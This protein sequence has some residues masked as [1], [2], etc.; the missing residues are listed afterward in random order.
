MVPDRVCII[1]AGAA[2]LCAARHSKRVGLSPVVFEASSVLGGTWVYT[3][4]VGNSVHSSMYKNL[5]TNLPKEVMG[6]PDYPFP[7]AKT[8]GRSF[9]HHS[10]VLEYLEDYATHFDL[11]GSIRF[12]TKVHL[13]K[14]KPYEN[15]WEVSI[16][17]LDESTGSRHH[18][19]KL[20]FDAIMVC[21]GHYYVPNFPTIPGLH[22]FQGIKMHSRSYKEPELFAGKTVL[23]IG[24]GASGTD[25]SLEICEKAKRVYLSH[26]GKRILSKLPHNLEVVP[27]VASCTGGKSFFL[28]DNKRSLE[29]VD[30]L[31]FATGYQHYYPFIDDSCKISVSASL[32][33]PLFKRIINASYPTMCFIGIPF[34]ICPNPLFD[35]QVQFFIQSLIGNV[36]LPDSEIMLKEEEERFKLHIRKGEKLRYYNQLGDSQ[37]KYNDDLARLGNF[38]PLLQ[39]MQR[40]FEE[41]IRRKSTSVTTYKQDCYATWVEKPML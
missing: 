18:H 36:K 39:Y 38:P 23:T 31:F 35:R 3:E 11:L 25:I 37:W 20:D 17:N 9:L 32:V 21:S 24:A 40:I 16:E 22:E 8:P 29:D 10:E 13:V 27:K 28:N 1:G 12:R 26:N 6:F 30:V 4:K 15:K 7:E 5:L 2:G 19:E 41:V 34:K 14:R 33:R